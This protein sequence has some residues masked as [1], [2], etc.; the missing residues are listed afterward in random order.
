MKN[1]KIIGIAIFI[2]LLALTVTHIALAIL[3]KNNQSLTTTSVATRTVGATIVGNGTIHSEN[4]AT[5]HFQTSGKL[6]YLPFKEGDTIVQGQSIAQLDTYSLQKQLTQ[7]LNNYKSTRDTFDQTQQNNSTGVLQGSQ[8]Y[9]LDVLNK[10]GVSGDNESSIINDMAKRIVDQNQANLD[11]SVINVELATYA[12]Q[13]ATLTAPFNGVITHED[14]T[15]PNV[16]VT[17]TTSFSLADPS[18]LVFRANVA[19]GDI[20]FVSVG[21]TATIRIAGNSQPFT[22]QVTKIYPQKIILPSGQ[23]VY[24]VDITNRG[25]ATA[26]HLGQS[27]NVL[28]QSNVQKEV[29]LVPTW[30]IIEH[31]YIWV[32]EGNQPVCKRVVLGKTHGDMTEIVSGLSLNDKVIVDPKGIAAKKYLA[33]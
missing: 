5:L 11:N 27:G 29:T 25:L 13:L 6:T 30:T 21:A 15:T 28:I 2:G 7:A 22:G 10:S 24:Q 9:S 8:K 20:D 16:N 12:L 31:T 17:P 3:Q 26:T 19:A 32:M 1:K 4:E 14:V 23:E 33:L 18:A